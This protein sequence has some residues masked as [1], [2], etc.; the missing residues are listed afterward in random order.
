MRGCL[1]PG[2]LLRAVLARRGTIETPVYGDARPDIARIRETRRRTQLLL[3]DACALQL[4]ICVRT[5]RRHRAAMAEAGVYMGGSARLICEAKGEARLHLF[6]LFDSAPSSAIRPDE[7]AVRAYFGEV[8]GNRARVEKV[9]APYPGVILHEGMFPA[10]ATAAVDERFGFVHLDLDLPDSTRAALEFFHPRLV[11]GGIILGDDHYDA[12]LRRT[13][14]DFF[15][16]RPDTL[17]DLPWGQ[18]MI[19]RQPD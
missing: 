10:T 11:A 12:G 6:D 4:L 16:G 17:F 13:F 14:S 9:L 15:A 18:V 3:G 8:R 19:V 7:Q 2:V 5:A 1:R